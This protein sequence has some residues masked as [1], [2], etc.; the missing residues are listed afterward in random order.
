VDERIT[1]VDGDITKLRVDA[2]VNAANEALLPGGGVCGAIHRAA[3]SQLWEECRRIG[4]CDPGEAVLTRGYSLPAKWVIHTVG[5]VWEGGRFGE[6]TV[7]ARCYQNSLRLAEE[8]GIRSIA[9]PAISTGVYGYPI[10]RSAHIAAGSVRGYL[11][12]LTAIEQVLLVCFDDE[13]RQANEDALQT[14]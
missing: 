9:F 5:P 3:G 10:D 12:Q 1:L 11:K 4:H 8:N 6:D 2:I 14:T 13:T 7:L